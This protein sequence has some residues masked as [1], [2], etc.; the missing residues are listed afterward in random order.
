M[1]TTIRY[2]DLV[3]SI[4]ASLQY[5]SYYHPADFIAHLARAYERGQSPAAN[6][7]MAQILTNSKMSATGQ[8]PIC[9]DT[10]IVNV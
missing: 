5:I 7:A 4:A 2:H 9:Q 3:E 8:R 6:D 1:T 10:G